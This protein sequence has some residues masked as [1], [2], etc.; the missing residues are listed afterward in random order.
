MPNS[1]GLQLL[2]EPW[3]F[4]RLPGECVLDGH[5]TVLSSSEEG[6]SD[7]AAELLASELRARGL[8][9]SASSSSSPLASLPSASSEP[10][11]SSPVAVS[12]TVAP[13]ATPS[14]LSNPLGAAEGY[15][16]EVTP[17]TLAIRASSP[18]GAFYAVQT[19]LHLLPPPIP[20]KR[21]KKPDDPRCYP[22]SSFSSL[23]LP[24]LEVADAPRFAWRG[25]L[26]DVARHFF[27]ARFIVDLI[28]VISSFKLN[29]L[30]LHLV[31]DQGWRLPC[32]EVEREKGA[33]KERRRE[34][35]G[36]AGETEEAPPLP[37]T[38]E[39]A[40]AAPLASSSS[41]SSFSSSFPLISEL[42]PWRGDSRREAMEWRSER[43]RRR[44]RRR[45]RKEKGEAEEGEKV[46]G[47]AA[48]AASEKED[49]DETLGASPSSS[50][51]ESSSSSN[52]SSY[53]EDGGGGRGSGGRRG[54][55]GMGRNR[56]RSRVRAGGRFS[57]RDISRILEAAAA[58]HVSVVP[59]VDLPGHCG[60]AIAAY[61]G[62]SCEGAAG[63]RDR[64]REA[65]AAAAAAA[66]AGV[67]NDGDGA[68]QPPSPDRNRFSVPTVWGVHPHV[69]CSSSPLALEFAD[70]L[71]KLT[72]SLFPNS[73][74]VHVGG[75]EVPLGPWGN[76]RGC[77]ERAAG[78]LL[79]LEGG[80]SGSEGPFSGELLHHFFVSRA[81]AALRR[82]GRR[83]VAWCDAFDAEAAARRAVAGSAA[84]ANA[85]ASAPSPP[86][87]PSLHP[88]ASPLSSS[89]SSVVMCWR[90]GG[91]PGARAAAEGRDVVMCPA[92]RC[93]LDY[94]QAEKVKENENGEK[95]NE[96]PEAE[97]PGAWY[98]S[99]TLRE[100]WE[101]DPLIVDE[102]VAVEE[103]EEKE[104]NEEEERAQE[105][106]DEGSGSGNDGERAHS[107]ELTLA[108]FGEGAAAG[109]E[110]RRSMSGTESN[111]A[112]G[113][114][115]RGGGGDDGDG[116]VSS[117]LVAVVGGEPPSQSLLPPP[118]YGTSLAMASSA[119]EEDDAD[120]AAT[121]SGACGAV[122]GRGAAGE[123]EEEVVGPSA[124]AA[125]SNG[126]D[127]KKTQKA[128]K[129]RLRRVPLPLSSHPRVLGGQACLWTEYV[130]NEATAAYMLFPRLLATSESLWSP[131]LAERRAFLTSAESDGDND[132]G[133]G[134][135]DEGEKRATERAWRDFV[136][137]ARAQGPRLDAA[138]W[139]ERRKL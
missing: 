76:C 73:R 98:A 56:R 32:D 20:K 5:V 42:G 14:L 35:G 53:S 43:R 68:Q 3:R 115:G 8:S 58:C 50:E 132:D 82:L 119:E 97:E 63:E 112:G 93:Y 67:E 55:G 75:D 96:R 125:A 27:P 45:R 69:L 79:P 113:G 130:S 78:L 99:L 83:S 31:D 120:G 81:E 54:E 136:S 122:T 33:E 72:A 137:R 89:S 41:P 126:D 16:I 106:A 139:R 24:C 133:G 12:V 70:S 118:P 52:S 114:G 13:G 57:A 87:S 19:L 51:A 80:G 88:P 64:E 18:A 105:E 10:E 26:L 25:L 117:R 95:V 2:P 90:G 11:T 84:D 15:E 128:R 62:L 101:F 48:A 135:P 7:A 4:Q 116:G 85:N 107:E 49:D 127:G 47:A 22:S 30:H 111:A 37:T 103:E 123:E 17:T 138:G 28:R 9:S 66:A 134:E 94:R 21:L 71:L 59:E 61:P 77:R 44:L 100:C 65:A 92:S 36:G 46:E 23:T 74:F 60:A 29:V 110:S 40:A 39:A 131:A 129:F 121:M 38:T 108:N 91:V 104:E 34:E 1:Q 102:A 109:R 86:V 124:A 6:A